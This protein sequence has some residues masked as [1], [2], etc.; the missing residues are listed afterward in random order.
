[1]IIAHIYPTVREAHYAFEHDLHYNLLDINKIR[2]DKYQTNDGN[3]HWYISEWEYPR[4]A[5]GRT[6]MLDGIMYRNGFE[7]K[8]FE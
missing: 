6:Y 7:I 4:W 5:R 2:V 1:M 8:R 3:E